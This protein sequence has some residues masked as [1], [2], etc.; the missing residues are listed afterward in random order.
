MDH[1][2]WVL[3]WVWLALP[4]EQKRMQ[5]PKL[6][7]FQVIWRANQLGKTPKRRPDSSVLHGVNQNACAI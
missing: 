6:R 5:Q 1:K 4:P 7:G 2:K 3:Y